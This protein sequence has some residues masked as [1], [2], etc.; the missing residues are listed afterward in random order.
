MLSSRDW[1]LIALTALSLAA[2]LLLPAMPQPAD[3]H[4]FADARPL[5]GIANFLDVVS[6]AGFLAVG[7]GGLALLLGGRTPFERRAERWPYLFFFIGVLLTAVGSGYYHLFP[8]NERLV[9]DRLPMTIA[10]MSLIAAQIAERINLRLGLA[11]LLPLIVIGFASVAYWIATERTGAGNVIPYGV[12]QAWAV[13]MLLA[14]T[15]FFQSRYTRGGDLYWVFAGYL[16][17]K[18][19]ETFDRDLFAI[20]H[21]VSGHTLKHL[22]AAV[23]AFFVLRMLMLR[24]PL[25]APPGLSR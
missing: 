23:A 18:L 14:L 12:L 16:S 25:A 5:F 21:L 4:R 22:A 6:N 7:I 1:T 11:L 15:V 24:R 9:W 20:G 8:D 3:Y 10:F 13:V 19:L 17:A 2:A